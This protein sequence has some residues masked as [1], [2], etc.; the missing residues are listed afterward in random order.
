MAGKKNAAKKKP[1]QKTKAPSKQSKN[2][3]KQYKKECFRSL[4]NSIAHIL[5][6]LS[7]VYCGYICNMF[8]IMCGILL[9]PMIFMVMLF[10]RSW[11]EYFRAVGSYYDKP[12]RYKCY[13]CGEEYEIPFKYLKQ[14]IMKLPKNR[15][16]QRYRICDYCGRHISISYQNELERYEEFIK[17]TQI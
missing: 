10:A 15:Q 9:I 7:L 16:G 12:F 6:L 2:Q 1:Q 5:F 3:I 13:E 14:S 17:R 4:L 8:W 11:M